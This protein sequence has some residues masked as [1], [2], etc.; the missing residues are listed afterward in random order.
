MK[1][2][3]GVVLLD[4]L[5]DLQPDNTYP[6]LVCGS[7]CGGNRALAAQ[8]K[9]CHVQAVFLN[10][11][12]VGKNH[13]GIRGLNHYEAENVLACA[14]DQNSAEIGISLDTW[15]SGIISHMNPKAEA[16]GIQ[17]GDSVKEAVHK[18]SSI[19]QITSST[20]KN[21]AADSP[22]KDETKNSSS[23]PEL[24][25]QTQT[26]IDGIDITVTDSIT[27]LNEN[28][29]GDIVICGSHGGMSAGHY[30]Q[31][32]GVKAVF[33]NDAGIGKNNAGVKSLESLSEA[34][35]L[36]CTV[37]CMSAEIFNGQDILDNGI[38]TVCNV[39]A[40]DRGI[41]EKMTVKESIKLLK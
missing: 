40:K 23:K 6:I 39:L 18:L 28:N 29:A 32:R 17:I 30:A 34:G 10:S 35:I 36:A 4:S 25:V 12:G 2:P 14:V 20:E 15:E 22:V 7:H 11:A 8:V 31:K 38:I 41:T 13:A 5:G 9:Y 27:F 33:F 19:I 37:D 26:Q 3:E 24:K 16:A 1:L 21:E